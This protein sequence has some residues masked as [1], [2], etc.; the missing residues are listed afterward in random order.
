MNRLQLVTKTML[1]KLDETCFGYKKVSGYPHLF[2]VS[3]I[4]MQLASVR[5][6]NIELCGCMG[7]LHD[8]ATYYTNT[9]FDHA[10]RSAMLAKE[11]LQD[12]AIFEDTEIEIVCKAIQHHSDKTTI[13]DEYS[14]LL[15]DSDVLCQYLQDTNA[16]Y[17]E[18]RIE[19]LHNLKK[20]GFL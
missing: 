14:E 9:S 3:T 7:L 20:Q 8:F 5:H 13:H 11:I 2:G 4:C 16:K 18:E 6:L 10:N 15:K 1:Q 12:L 19:R 17:P